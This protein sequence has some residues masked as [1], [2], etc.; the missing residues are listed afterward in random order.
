MPSFRPKKL[1]RKC[2]HLTFRASL[3]ATSTIRLEVMCASQLLHWQGPQT[4]RQKAHSKLGSSFEYLGVQ[5]NRLWEYQRDSLARIANPAHG[6]SSLLLDIVWVLDDALADVESVLAQKR[7]PADDL[8]NTVEAAALLLAHII[9]Y[10]K[11]GSQS[12]VCAAF[13][14]FVRVLKKPPCSDIVS[15]DPFLDWIQ[16]HSPAT[17][18]WIAV[19]VFP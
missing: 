12:Q 14:N 2:F 5:D 6:D 19:R 3:R 4:H 10:I 11:C 7:W 16:D 8:A 13:L 9:P 1:T 15:F 18:S 17:M